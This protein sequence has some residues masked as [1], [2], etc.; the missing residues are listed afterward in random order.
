MGWTKE[1]GN[2][3]LAKGTKVSIDGKRHG[4]LWS[5]LKRHFPLKDKDLVIANLGKKKVTG[6]PQPIYQYRV[7]LLEDLKNKLGKK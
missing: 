2:H 4:N 6:Y 5:N 1:K 7:M 3:E